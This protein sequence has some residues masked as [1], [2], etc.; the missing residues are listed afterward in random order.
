M[1][2]PLKINGIAGNQHTSAEYVIATLRIPRKDKDGPAEAIIT[3]EL[4]IVDH[5]DANILVG[6]DVILPKKMDILLSDKILRI[7][8]YNVDILVQLQIYASY[9]QHLFP[10]HAKAT[11]TILLQS[12]SIVPIHLLSTTAG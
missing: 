8:T 12:A 11:T 2:S 10:V 6:T 4:H 7:G 1:A 5:L 3:R 9:Q